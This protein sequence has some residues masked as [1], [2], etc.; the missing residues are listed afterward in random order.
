MVNC[1]KNFPKLSLEIKNKLTNIAKC[2]SEHQEQNVSLM[3]GMSGLALF[4]AYY[5]EYSDSV[6]LEEDLIP[7]ISKISLGIKKG[8]VYP[9]FSSG[10]AGFGWVI[11]N[12]NQNSF[13]EVDTDK[14]IG[15]FD[16]I[17]YNYMIKC[18]H[19]GDFDYLHG[20][21]G[22]GL[23]Y[24]S[25]LSNPKAILYITQ[26]INELEKQSV[27][28]LDGIAWES[29]L[30][31]ENS[32]KVYNLSLSH[33]MPSLICLLSRFYEANI[34]R[35]KAR[36]LVEG[37][38]KY[39]LSCQR[40]PK[41]YRFKFPSWM[42]KNDSHE[43]SFSR[44]SWCYNDLGVALALLQAANIFNN[45]FW[46]QE[47][48]DTLLLTTTITNWDNSNVFDAGLCHGSTGIAHLYNRAYN[49]TGIEKFRDSAV[50]WFEITLKM[51]KYLDG[52]AGY[53]AFRADQNGGMENC[54]GLLEGIAGIGLAM[55][56]AVSEIE[57]AW[58][59]ALLLS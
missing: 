55:I 27:P 44:L 49:Y 40:D 12:L 3:G 48:V 24:L 29:R 41:L 2:L 53:K 37:A 23:Y 51:A 25:R 10:L 54:F 58:D 7:I 39:L 11:E 50:Y 15:T 42:S 47:A 52:P 43:G 30:S 19:Q 57:P 34:N 18:I 45:D 26:L 46:K 32:E 59:R 56:S 1:L 33:G 5:S 28:V 17:L 22:I 38:V 9:A 8:D 6:S 35:E 4:W 13:I 14:F 31:S 36:V 16:D 20:A 21:S